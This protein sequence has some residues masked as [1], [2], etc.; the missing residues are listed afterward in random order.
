M[1]LTRDW[2]DYQHGNR[3]L[4][5]CGSIVIVS[6]KAA[7]IILDKGVGKLISPTNKQPH[8]G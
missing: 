1:K 3:M 2:W 5:R 8:K 4:A 7:Q 6:E